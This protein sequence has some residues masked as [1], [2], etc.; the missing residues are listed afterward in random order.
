MKKIV[1]NSPEIEI[2]VVSIESCFATSQLEDLKDGEEI[3]W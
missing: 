1:Y 3:D 2:I